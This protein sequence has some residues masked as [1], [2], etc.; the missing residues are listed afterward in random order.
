MNP[1]TR[2]YF[3]AWS[4]CPVVLVLTCVAQTV[5]DT[6]VFG[7]WVI[8]I[9]FAAVVDS[10]LMDAAGLILLFTGALGRQM[11]P[12]VLVAFWPLAAL[13]I[14]GLHWLLTSLR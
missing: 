14:V 5:F 4:V 8:W 11:I 12:T 3:I 13:A 10:V 7:Y 6:G 9:V 2:W 1:T